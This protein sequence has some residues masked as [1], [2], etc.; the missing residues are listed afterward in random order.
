MKKLVRG[1]ADAYFA[2]QNGE[3]RPA[4]ANRL[5]RIAYSV[6]RVVCSHYEH[7]NAAL[8]AEQRGALDEAIE[9]AVGPNKKALQ[10]LSDAEA[11]PDDPRRLKAWSHITRYVDGPDK[12]KSYRS[13][14]T[15]LV[16]GPDDAP[17][18]FQRTPMVAPLGTLEITDPMGAFPLT[19]AVNNVTISVRLPINRWEQVTG[20][21][22]TRIHVNERPY[23]DRL[24]SLTMDPH[25][26]GGATIE[27]DGQGNVASL[28]L[29]ISNCSSYTSAD[30]ALRQPQVGPLLDNIHASVLA[31]QQAYNGII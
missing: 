3:R 4:D 25:F 8:F 12:G 18:G 31:T 24:D 29:D 27:L 1:V 6:G 2:G 10:I 14:H 20:L 9:A 17:E 15:S 5:G 22:E 21:P 28:G 30:L 11:L 23:E 13:W 19:T 26:M 7:Q 16:Y